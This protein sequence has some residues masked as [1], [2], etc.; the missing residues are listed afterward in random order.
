LA[1]GRTDAKGFTLAL[2]SPEKKECLQWWRYPK[3]CKKP[4][5]HS[6]L[7]PAGHQ[8]DSELDDI[9]WDID[10]DEDDEREIE[11]LSCEEEIESEVFALLKFP[12][13]NFHHWHIP[14]PCL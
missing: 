14:L 8:H 13:A 4:E 10:K 5:N 6:T 2:P 7:P 12:D 3:E 1:K 11:Y 9:R